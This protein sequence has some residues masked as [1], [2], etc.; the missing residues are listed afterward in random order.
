MAIAN[1]ARDL[2]PAAHFLD[3]GV[4]RAEIDTAV[5]HHYVICC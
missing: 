4:E 5:T 2:E 3:P 1:P